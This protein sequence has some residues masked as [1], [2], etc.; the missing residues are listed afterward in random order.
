[1]SGIGVNC[2]YPSLDGASGHG[3]LHPYGISIQLMLM[4]TVSDA[5]FAGRVFLLRRFHDS[6]KLG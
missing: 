1:M 5:T 3:Y 2:S 4:L 6:R